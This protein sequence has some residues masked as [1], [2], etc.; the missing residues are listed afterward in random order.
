MS[1][2]DPRNQKDKRKIRRIGVFLT[3]LIHALVFGA[4]AYTYA[5]VPPDPPI[6]K[7]GMTLNIGEYY[8]AQKGKKPKKNK[9][10]KD[11]ASKKVEQKKTTQKKIQKQE[12]VKPVEFEDVVLSK[13][14]EAV[15]LKDKVKEQVK[16]EEVKEVK[17]EKTEAVK[18]EIKELAKEVLKTTEEEGDNSAD[19]EL[20]K[21]DYADAGQ[22][23]GKKE[24]QAKT[25]VHGENGISLDLA[26][27]VW[28]REPIVN[29]ETDDTGMITLQLTIDKYGNIIDTQVIRTTVGISTVKHF[30]NAVTKSKFKPIGSGRFEGN[31]KG[32]VTF[33]TGY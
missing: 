15:V 19:G 8:E 7:K 6:P 9:V 2:L 33:S 31:T 29:D 27:W 1:N 4:L 20:A 3:V 32:T 28:Q 12:E 18:E 14:E 16:L 24:G 26:G 11:N 10:K 22:Q 13:N 30:K 21:S 17:E 23:N 25:G 5:W